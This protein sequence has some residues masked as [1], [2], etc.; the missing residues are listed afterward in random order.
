MKFFTKKSITQK[1]IIVAIISILFGFAFPTYSQAGIGG[2]LIDPIVDFVGVLFDAVVGGL[3]MFLV[4]GTFNNSDSGTLRNAFLVDVDDFQKNPDKYSEFTYNPEGAAIEE[5]SEDELSKNMWGASNYFIPALKYTPQKIFSGLVPALDANF[6]NPN[7]WEGD[8]EKQERSVALEL[9]ETISGWY[10]ALRNLAI[11]GLMSVLL[12]VGIRIIISSAASEKSKYKQMLVDW[13]VAMCLIFCLHYIMAFTTTIVTEISS[14]IN[15]AEKNNGNNIAVRVVETKTAEN[16]SI[17]DGDVSNNSVK[18]GGSEYE[19]RDGNQVYQ[20]SN[21]MGEVLSP[22]LKVNDQTTV[23]LVLEQYNKRNNGNTDTTTTISTG[24]GVQ[25]N[26]DL[27]G[28]IRFKMQSNNVWYK[29]LYLIFYMAMVMYTCLFTF[30]YLKRVLTIAFLTLISPLVA[31]TYPIDKIRDGKAQAFNMWLKE[32]VFNILIQPFH[33]I[34]YTVFVSSAIDLAAKNPIFAIVALAFIGPAEKILR[35]FFGFNE[36]KTGGTLSSLAGIAGGTAAFNMVSKALSKGGKGGGSQPQKGNETIKTKPQG[37][38]PSLGETYADSSVRTTGEETSESGENTETQ[39]NNTSDWYAPNYNTGTLPEG[40]TNSP[41]QESSGWYAPNSNNDNQSLWQRAW[42]SDENDTR[43]LGQYLKDGVGTLTKPGL[44][45]LAG[46]PVGQKAIRFK[47]STKKAA[48]AVQSAKGSINDAV[49]GIGKNVPRPIKNAAKGALGVGKYVGKKAIRTAGK[50][51]SAVPGAMFG[52]AAGIAGDEL[53][54]IWKYTAAGGALSTAA[55]PKVSSSIQSGVSN[56]KNAYN[57]GKY[58]EQEA[59]K[60]ERINNYVKS[61]DLD[62]EYRNR[63]KNE[64]GSELTKAQLRE[65]K[66]R[67]AYFDSMG[68]EGKDSVKAVVLQDQIKRELARSMDEQEAEKK[69]QQRAAVIANLAKSYDEKDLRDGGKVEKLRASIKK[70]LINAN[71][72]AS[73]AGKQSNEII[74]QVKAFRG[75][76]DE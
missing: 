44:E 53:G 72:G 36:A 38:A 59:A 56:I 49:K 74:K 26:T 30:M 37:S 8:T 24:T 23:N 12:Y 6:V 32:Y 66:E 40:S 1:I 73:E 70:E 9:R 10:V 7:Q 20:I 55:I 68:I 31:F 16:S 54:D 22:P 33:L 71:M 61:E 17:V 52:M 19:V 27:M 69:S 42:Q 75:V 28:L 50:V 11:I 13:L 67:G 47:N 5:I 46:T 4:D 58:G 35:N 3:Q 29:L 65:A 21:A 39:D 41:V 45:K 15:G 64:D 2:V 43:G 48:E 62:A 14:A 57:V 25:F 18:I 34:I 63:I 51:A 60:I 76:K